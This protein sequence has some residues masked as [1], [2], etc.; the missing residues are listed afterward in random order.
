VNSVLFV[1]DN[2]SILAGLRRALR[3]H[4]K[5][6]AWDM[7]FVE[8]PEAALVELTAAP[9]DVV[10]SDFRMPSMDGAQFLTEVRD[11]FPDTIRIV[12]SGHTDEVDVTRLTTVAHQFITKPCEFDDLVG[13]VDRALNLHDQLDGEQVRAA[14]LSLESL[15]SMPSTVRRLLEVIDNP[16]TPMHTLATLVEGDV[17]L[18]SKLLQLVNSSFF[19]TRSRPTSLES[20]IVRL[21]SRTVRSIAL[22]DG[23]GTALPAPVQ[24]G[25]GWLEGL[26]RH[27]MATAQLA[28]GLAASG[29]R[30]DAFCAGLLHECGQL[31]L[32][33]GNPDL[34]DA[35]LAQRRAQN[36]SLGECEQE[37]L[38]VT[39]AQVGAYLL[40]AWGFPLEIVD[41]VANHDDVEPPDEGPE[42]SL[43]AVVQLAHEVVEAERLSLCA[44]P[45][46]PEGHDDRL[47]TAALREALS[48]W[49][50]LVSQSS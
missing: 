1:D 24:L 18:S 49:R 35:A 22:L 13:I 26:N 44:A 34:F 15:P 29:D 33:A 38:G 45:S 4:A 23:I 30:D 19:A 46:P 8:S 48:Q 40:S 16:D 42:L 31:A 28:A 5:D 14:A 32:A 10:V 12:L 47:D 43:R 6:R 37:V 9:A 50:E 41:A 20:A 39:H 7:R 11:H 25:A 3:A 2:A 36:R 17:G 21:G 27:A